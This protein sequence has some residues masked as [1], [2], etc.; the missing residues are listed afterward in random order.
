MQSIPTGE[1]PIPSAISYYHF[2]DESYHFNSSCLIGTE[3]IDALPPPTKFERF[4]GNLG[5]KAASVT[6]VIIQRL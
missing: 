3:V 4:V 5:I 2:M 1:R 6:T